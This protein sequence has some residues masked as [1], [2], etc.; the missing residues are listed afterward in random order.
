[1]GSG[2][3]LDVGVTADHLIEYT[4]RDKGGVELL[5]SPDRASNNSRWILALDEKARLWFYSGDVGTF[6]WVV[7]QENKY[8]EVPLAGQGEL[9]DTM[10]REL[11]NE[12][13]SL[14]RKNR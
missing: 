14:V 6:A 9:W 10:P 5:R 8:T 2:Y 7:N 11:C 1:V 4:L 13:P 3:T 12:L